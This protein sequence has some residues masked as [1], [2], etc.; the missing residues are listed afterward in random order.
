MFKTI[1]IVLLIIVVIWQHYVI[2]QQQKLN[3]DILK[4]LQKT[5]SNFERVVQKN[6]KQS[7]VIEFQKM[8]IDKIEEDEN[9]R[10]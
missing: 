2:K 7:E 3:Q 4:T 1:I 9:E 10:R 5:V 6:I 8:I